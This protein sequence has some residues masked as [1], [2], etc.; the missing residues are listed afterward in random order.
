MLDQI[1]TIKATSA[2][3]VHRLTIKCPDCGGNLFSVGQ[4]EH[5]VASQFNLLVSYRC[6]DH[7]K[8]D[9]GFE[10]GHRG[11]GTAILKGL[12]CFKTNT[13]KF[14]AIEVVE[15]EK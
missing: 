1:E 4:S 11:L 8:C 6:E 9:G 7:L 2:D 15:N 5:S 13:I 14:T 3:Q 12:E 10:V